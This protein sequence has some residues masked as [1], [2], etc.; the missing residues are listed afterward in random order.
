MHRF[1]NI[2]FVA[3]PGS[4]FDPALRRA[5]ELAT[6]NKGRLTIVQL[7]TLEPD[8]LTGDLGMRV[9]GLI[10]EIEQE[11]SKELTRL[12][13]AV[14]DLGVRPDTRLL[15]GKPFLSIVQQVLRNGHD[16]VMKKAEGSVGGF[17]TRLFG[18]TDQHLMRKCPVPVWLF[19]QNDGS[20]YRSILAAVDVGQGGNAE[21]NA[22][23]LQLASS[24]AAREGSELHVVHAWALYGES[25]LRSPSRGVS[26]EIL[27]QLLKDEE[28][29][30]RRRL[31]AVAEAEVVPEVEAQLH[32]LKAEAPEGIGRI[33]ESVDADLV[34]MGTLSRAGVRGLLIGNTAETV[35]GRLDSSVLTVKPEGF[36]TPVSLDGPA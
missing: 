31:K 30:R 2:L 13:D 19:K 3:T 23:I 18:S 1:K 16:L 12:A 15:R 36:Q 9:D 33:A 11:Q 21:L 27:T 34:V 29:E 6:V 24:L 20:G 22:K 26:R 10:G 35:L 14:E 17:R 32:V 28:S 8:A 5:V 7:A 4:G 25:M